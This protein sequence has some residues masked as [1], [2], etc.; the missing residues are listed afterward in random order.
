MK[1]QEVVLERA[2]EASSRGMQKDLEQVYANNP[3]QDSPNPLG[4]ALGIGGA[5]SGANDRII[6]QGGKGFLPT[7]LG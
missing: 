2:Y 1:D 4:L 5:A 6:D 3:M 7:F